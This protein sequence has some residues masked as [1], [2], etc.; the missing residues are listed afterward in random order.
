[1]LDR[2]IAE[3]GRFPAIDLQKSLSRMLPGCHSP[4][5]YEITKVARKALGR[6]AD[7]E[8][9]IRLGAYKAGSDPETDQAIT[10]FR[11]ASPFLSQSRGDKTSAAEGFADTYRMILESGIDDPL[12]SFFE[13]R[14]RAEAT[15]AQ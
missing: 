11:A 10:F 1:V 8:D 5:E 4:E 2:R 12:R 14:A 13:E 15:P 7:M 3:Q 9:L 6:Y